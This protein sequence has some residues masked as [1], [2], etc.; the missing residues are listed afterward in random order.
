MKTGLNPHDEDWNPDPHDED[1]T[2]LMMKT[3]PD[4]HD[5]DWTTE[6]SLETG[7]LFGC[8]SRHRK[9]LKALVNISA[10]C[11]KDERGADGEVPVQRSEAL[12]TTGL[13]PGLTPGPTPGLTP[14]PPPVLLRDLLT[15][16]QL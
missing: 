13:T 16:G 12:I 10:Q 3:G 14:G 1:W 7:K 9:G 4:S 2:R 6:S 11:S 15:S 5:E 8:S